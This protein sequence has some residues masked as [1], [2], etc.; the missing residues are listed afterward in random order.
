MLNPLFHFVPGWALSSRDRLATEL[1]RRSDLRY[2]Y[3]NTRFAN[4][5]VELVFALRSGLKGCVC[6][7]SGVPR[8]FDVTLRPV[9]GRVAHSQHR[10]VAEVIDLLRAV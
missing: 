7:S 5:R 3:T 10:N 8:P 9:G 1:R 4:G 6:I 2:V